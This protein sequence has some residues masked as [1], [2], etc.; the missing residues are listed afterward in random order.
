M[1]QERGKSM[2]AHFLRMSLVVGG[3]TLFCRPLLLAQEATVIV[4]GRLLD[5]GTGAIARNQRIL[6]EDGRVKEVG[7]RVRQPANARVVDLSRY[8]VL[9]GLIDAHVHLVI[10][11]PVRD[12]ALADLRAGFTTV[13]DL[14]ARTQRLLQIADSINAGHIPGPRVLAAG[15]WVGTRGGVCEFNGIGIAGGPEAFALRVRENVEAGAAVIKVC[16]SGWPAAAYANP[17]SVE[18][19]SATLAAVVGAAREHKKPV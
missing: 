7:R 17:I 8:T 13:V 12:N 6:I 10:G 18:L 15:V 9:P 19:D 1:S 3:L 16:L 14:G 2:T 5:P 11:G 4:A